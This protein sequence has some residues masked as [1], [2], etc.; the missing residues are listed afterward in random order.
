MSL[1]SVQQYVTYNVQH[2]LLI[3][4]LHKDGITNVDRHFRG[5]DHSKMTTKTRLQIRA[6]TQHLELAPPEA[7]AIPSA[8][9]FPIDGLE[10][11]EDGAK[12]NECEYVARTTDTM[13][14]HC[15]IKHDWKLKDGSMW[16][17]QAVQS[18]FQGTMQI[19]LTLILGKYRKFFAV[20]LPMST[21]NQTMTDQLIEGQKMHTYIDCRCIA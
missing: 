9:S 12:C 8:N 20:M 1:E 4:K 5:I 19:R 17:K 7:M 15:R 6:A 18:F 3:C 13:E 10:L 11:I 14:K 21:E 16:T 2:K